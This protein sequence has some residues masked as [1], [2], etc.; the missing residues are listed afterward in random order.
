MV[1]FVEM[2]G[3]GCFNFLNLTILTISTNLCII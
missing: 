2:E 3:D 1:E